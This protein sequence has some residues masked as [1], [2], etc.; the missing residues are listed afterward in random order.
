MPKELQSAEMRGICSCRYFLFFVSVCLAFSIPTSSTDLIVLMKIKTAMIGPKG[1]GLDDWIVSS[2]RASHCLFSGV[3]C[4]ENSRVVSLNVSFVPLFGTIA[5]EIGLLN[6]LVNLTLSCNNLTGKFPAEI[7]NLTSLK[8]LNLSN[9]IMYGHVPESIFGGLLELEVF[10]IYNNNFSGPLPIE[11]VKLK[12]LKHLHLGGNYFSGEIPSVYCEIQSLEY[13]GLNGNGL[14]GK[15]PASLSRLSNLQELYIGYFSMYEG[16]IPPEFGSLSSLRMLDMGSCNLTGEIPASLG[17]LKLLHTLFL[18]LNR[19]SGLIPAELSGLVS[20]KSLDLSNNELTGE[21]PK[22]FSELKQLTLLNLFRNHLHGRIPSFIADLPY[23]EVLQLWENNFTFEL[24]VNLGSNGKLTKLDVATNH[25]TG[26]IPRHLCDGKR[27]ETLILMDNYF[28]GPVPEE[29]GDC[30]SLTRIRLMKNFFN[31][32]IPPGFFNL[33]LVDMLEFS[34]NYFTG[35]LPDEIS[36]GILGLLTLSNNRITGNVPA[37]IA[38]LTNLQTLS[39]ELNQFSGEIPPQIFDLKKLSK[40]NISNNNITGKI[41]TTIAHCKSL[42]LVDFSS[43]NLFG[44]IP[45]AIAKLEILSTLN[46]SRNQLEGQIP[47]EIRSMTSLTILDLSYNNLSGP[48]PEGGQFLVFNDS[49]F[50]GNPNLCSPLHHLSCLLPQNQDELSGQKSSSSK[51]AIIVVSIIGVLSF[52][53]AALKFNRYRIKCRESKAWKLTPFQKLDF[54]V[55]DV[56]EC[57]KEENIIGKGG[58]GIVYRGSMP[59]GMNVAIKR[60]VGSSSGRN[61]HGFSA[62]IQTLGRIRHRNIVKLLGFVSNNDTNLLIYEFMPN[63][64]LGGLLHGSKGSHLQWESRYRIAVEAA[65]GLCYLHHGCSPLIIHRDVKSNNILLDSDFAAH[66]ADFGLAK[67]LHSAGASECM[68]SVAGSY[69]YIAPEY[70]YTLRVDEKSDVYSFGVVLL[71]LITGR[72]PVGEFGDGVDIVRWVLKTI[73][74]LSEISKPSDAAAVLAVVDPRLSGYSLVGMI[75]LF[76]VA[77]RCVA[78]MSAERPTMMEVVHMLAG[79]PH[80]QSPPNLLAM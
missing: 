73:S 26:M 76:N 3:S 72:K 62:E 30:K 52:F 78:E 18:Q 21:I 75:N 19:L 56:V 53:A 5:P 68:S 63:G 64:C 36:G 46:L 37:A 20:L 16:G 22:G 28:F 14:S 13:L 58:A 47:I 48:V 71:E 35:K 43:N 51:V 44:E 24:P 74:E 31:G 8:L 9:N 61:D 42:T 12:R 6:N 11:L 41:P 40:M 38:N 60:L 23:L 49:S 80:P 67:F 54:K 65:K 34:D 69:G 45:R 17:R 66:V 25:L 2:S 15:V 10:D 1:S 39:L 59:N 33:P 32:T 57:L 77:M 4:D 70:A 27:L 29:L 79:P 50:T 7:A 55:E